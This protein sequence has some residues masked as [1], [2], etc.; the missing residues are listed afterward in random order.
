MNIIERLQTLPPDLRG[1]LPASPKVEAIR[2]IEDNDYY[3]DPSL[4]VWVQVP[5]DT[6]DDE[7]SWAKI[8]PIRDLMVDEV[9]A[10][11]DRRFPYIKFVTVS[12]LAKAGWK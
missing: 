2:V 4:Y 8:E 9:T 3:G 10:S 11:G 1:K 12:D 5:D 7:L 6:P